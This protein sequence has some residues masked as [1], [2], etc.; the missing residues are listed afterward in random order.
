MMLFLVFSLLNTKHRA[1]QH[2]VEIGSTGAN[3]K[4]PAWRLNSRVE[5]SNGWILDLISLI[6]IKRRAWQEA[7]LRNCFQT[8]GWISSIYFIF[9]AGEQ[10]CKCVSFSPVNQSVKSVIIQQICLKDLLFTGTRSK[11]GWGG[12]GYRKIGDTTFAL[13]EFKICEVEVELRQDGE[14]DRQSHP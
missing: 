14:A 10:I 9:T 8:C 7:S 6:T 3:G 11:L 5:V 2:K 4:E 13:E 1:G 12:E